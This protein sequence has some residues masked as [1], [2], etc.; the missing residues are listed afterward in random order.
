MCEREELETLHTDTKPRTSHHRWPGRETCTKRKLSTIFFERRRK[1]H[2]QSD[3]HWNC[4]KGKVGETSERRGGAHM[5][6]FE[7][8]TYRLELN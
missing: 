1:R 8:H 2:C 7:G 5:G 6:L 4:F 3:E